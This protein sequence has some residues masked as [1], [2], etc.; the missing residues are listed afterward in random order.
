[1]KKIH[2][3][4]NTSKQEYPIII[5]QNVLSKISKLIPLSRNT[6]IFIITDN[7]VKP[8]FLKK[9]LANL[10]QT[11]KYIVLLP[12]EKSKTIQTVETIWTAMSDARLDRKSLVLNLGGGVIGDMGGFAASTYMRG[13]DF[14]QIPTTLL[15][16]IDAS[17]GG[18][19]GIDFAGIKNLI[20]TFQQPLAVLIDTETLK[21]LPK[22]ELISGFGE[23]IKHGLIA[24]EA[25]FK[26]VIS[27][28]PKDFSLDELA[29]LIIKSCEIKKKIVEN[30]QREK[31][32]RKM[33]NFGHT[34]GH[35]IESLSLDT[36]KPL[37]H[38]EAISIGLVV[39]AKISQL[40]SMISDTDFEE[41][42]HGIKKCELPF[43]LPKE[44]RTS[45]FSKKFLQ[46]M[47]KDK[48]NEHGKN[49]FT[50]LNKLGKAVI[51]QH[52][53]D[54]LVIKA[55]KEIIDEK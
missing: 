18:K 21:T 36:E 49:N 11:T 28:K 23:L 13:I 22:R 20:G 24:D 14:I 33:L 38:G 29:E 47:K 34:V 37:L 8:H 30:D 25:Y 51:N 7:H 12:G 54:K 3:S 26:K 40:L 16:Q 1:M 5:G 55:L 48:K 43:T 31:G 53:S 10:P 42:K 52:V 27:K 44:L 4:F 39:E 46:K 50:L 6:K 15:S 35:A 2:V 41:I 32:N 45:N 17:V 19:T 9:V